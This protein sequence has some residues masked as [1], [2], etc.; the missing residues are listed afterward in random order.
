MKIA[1][2]LFIPLELM[3]AFSMLSWG[4]SGWFGGGALYRD[5]GAQGRNL[6]WG[7]TLCVIAGLQVAAAAIEWWIGRRWESG[8][9]EHWVRARTVIAFLAVCV[10]LY[11]AL[12]ICTA[13]NRELSFALFLQAPAGVFFAGWAFVGN[14]KV[15][16]LLDPSVPTVRLHQA[17]LAEREQFLRLR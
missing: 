12:F 16:C 7:V 3:L 5:L 13:G 2:R 8:L 9:L 14:L 10:W 4:L 11:M 17:I 6:E 1:S 15:L